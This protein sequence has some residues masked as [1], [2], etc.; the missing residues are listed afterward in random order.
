LPGQM[1]RP[2]CV[3]P[4][5]SGAIQAPAWKEITKNWAEVIKMEDFGAE[6]LYNEASELRDQRRNGMPKSY[7]GY[8]GLRVE[9]FKINPR[10]RNLT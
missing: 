8:P 1:G 2:D 4:G 6:M 5:A 10:G 3:L 9:T 7:M